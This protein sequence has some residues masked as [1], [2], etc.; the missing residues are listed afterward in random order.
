VKKTQSNFAMRKK[1]NRTLRCEKNL[2]ELDATEKIQ[3][4]E[5]TGVGSAPDATDVGKISVRP[6]AIAVVADVSY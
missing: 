4:R 6:D 1:L 2:I 5:R 3:R